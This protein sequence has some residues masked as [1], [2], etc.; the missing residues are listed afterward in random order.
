MPHES[1]SLSGAPFSRCSGQQ[2]LT[3]VPRGCGSG[4][5]ELWAA[6]F[7]GES[8]DLGPVVTGLLPK[9]LSGGLGGV[10]ECAPVCSRAFGKA[11]A[12]LCP[13]PM[14]F[15]L[16]EKAKVSSLNTVPLWQDLGFLG[17][18]RDSGGPGLWS[19]D[20]QCQRSA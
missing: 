1:H 17:V 10:R 13:L 15:Y 14:P 16:R 11:Q 12:T 2:P 20:A 19:S 18:G 6:T 5:K 9:H 8:A 7:L 3:L 4:T